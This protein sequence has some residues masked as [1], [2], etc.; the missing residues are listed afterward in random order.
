MAFIYS[1]ANGLAEELCR[2][3]IWI[4]VN[5][6]RKIQLKNLDFPETLLQY[7]CSAS[8]WQDCFYV[9]M[10]KRKQQSDWYMYIYIYYIYLKHT[11]VVYLCTYYPCISI[12]SCNSQNSVLSHSIACIIYQTCHF[13]VICVCSKPCKGRVKTWSNNLFRCYLLL[14]VTTTIF[15]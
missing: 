9:F 2:E 5:V 3:V 1:S 14:M 8:A 7:N 6:W 10:R 11:T 4:Q 12:F 13:D 15:M